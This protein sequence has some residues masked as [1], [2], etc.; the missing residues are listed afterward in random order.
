VPECVEQITKDIWET[1]L[2]FCI[3]HSNAYWNHELDPFTLERIIVECED[4]HEWI[5][6]PLYC[7]ACGVDKGEERQ[8]QTVTKPL[9]NNARH[10]P[11]AVIG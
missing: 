2:G 10:A 6:S 11:R 9:P 1:E 7:S 8:T 4:N 5:G 3:E